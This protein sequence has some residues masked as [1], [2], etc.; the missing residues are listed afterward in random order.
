MV[1]SAS[2]RKTFIDSAVAFLQKYDF[3]G[4]D[5]DWEYPGSRGGKAADKVNIWLS[6][7][8]MIISHSGAGTIHFLY[9]F[10]KQVF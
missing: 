10:V 6:K 8:K 5:F 4:L 3:Q 2:S 9:S 1:S 7:S